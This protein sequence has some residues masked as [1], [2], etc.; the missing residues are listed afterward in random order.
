MRS[1]ISNLLCTITESPPS[2]KSNILVN[3]LSDMLPGNKDET[4]VIVPSGDS[5]ESIVVLII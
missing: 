4:K 1:S 3:A 2:H 5:Y